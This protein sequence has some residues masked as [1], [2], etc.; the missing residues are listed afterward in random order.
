MF[1]TAEN[2]GGDVT[3]EEIQE[4][5]TAR[6][7]GTE[8]TVAILEHTPSY[9]AAR[10]REQVTKEGYNAAYIAEELAALGLAFAGESVTE[11]EPVVV[12]EDT[13]D[14]DADPLEQE[15]RR[16]AREEQAEG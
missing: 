11:P 10:T 16:R 12:E 4:N 9:W 15:H 7:K 1:M 14:V 8:E 13:D 5:I 6:L 3:E 2:G